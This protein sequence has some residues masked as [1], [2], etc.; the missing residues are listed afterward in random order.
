M[1]AIANI[2]EENRLNII[3]TKIAP[4]DRIR[5]EKMIQRLSERP[6]REEEPEPPLKRPKNCDPRP[7]ELVFE[8]PG[9]MFPEKGQTS[10]AAASKSH[11]SD[12]Q[13][14][15]GDKRLAEPSRHTAEKHLYTNDSI[16]NRTSKKTRNE[17]SSSSSAKETTPRKSVGFSAPSSAAEK[18]L[19]NESRDRLKSPPPLLEATLSEDDEEEESEDE[20]PRHPPRG[21]SHYSQ[22]FSKKAVTPPR[23]DDEDEYLIESDRE[24]NDQSNDATTEENV[25]NV[26][27]AVNPQNDVD[28]EEDSDEDFPRLCPRNLDRYESSFSTSN[29]AL[30]PADKIATP[31]QPVVRRS[32]FDF[33]DDDDIPPV[34]ERQRTIFFDEKTAVD[35]ENRPK[36]IDSH[37]GIS[38]GNSLQPHE[39][40]DYENKVNM[41]GPNPSRVMVAFP[42]QK[43][44]CRKPECMVIEKWISK[45]DYE[46]D[47]KEILSTFRNSHH[48]Q[49]TAELSYEHLF[50]FDTM[51][52][53]VPFET[54]YKRIQCIDCG[55]PNDPFAIINVLENEIKEKRNDYVMKNVFV[56]LGLDFLTYDPDEK[57]ARRNTALFF[58]RLLNQITKAFDLRNGPRRY[59]RS[60]ALIGDNSFLDVTPPR[61]TFITIPLVKA[62]RSSIS[63]NNDIIQM[64]KQIRAFV[65]KC[66]EAAE[67]RRCIL[68]I[69]DWEKTSAAYDQCN[70]EHLGKRNDILMKYLSIEHA[71]LMYRPDE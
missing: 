11:V 71:I 42:N 46:D 49:Q 26:D 64:N 3:I 62:T 34:P 63:L 23:N 51:L 48:L 44:L 4:E 10:S 35:N 38:L 7:V 59:K 60:T 28:E 32:M 15:S 39:T 68:E 9:Y 52:S 65:E 50:I 31:K 43:G 24:D 54:T 13:T 22:H 56:C 18:R 37:S 6:R 27:P 58:E 69:Y 41:E 61:I 29:S 16:V 1:V 25:L 53:G 40:I 19:N 55:H 14:S 2:I 67:K 33:S 70:E 12:V 45:P 8:P 36:E 5:I 30:Q 21:L 57:R 47:I 66:K 20:M 17:I